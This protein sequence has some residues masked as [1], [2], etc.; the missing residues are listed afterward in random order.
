MWVTIMGMVLDNPGIVGK[1]VTI[2]GKVSD[3][4]LDFGLDPWDGG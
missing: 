2:F 3:H 1:G 4:I